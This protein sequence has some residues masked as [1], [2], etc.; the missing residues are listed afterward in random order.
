MLKKLA[1]IP[2]PV[3]QAFLNLVDPFTKEAGLLLA[4]RVKLWRFKQSILLL[5]K[6]KKFLKSR[7]VR[8]EPV[9]LKFLSS[10]LE[11]GSL[12]EDDSMVD[13][14]ASLLAAAADANHKESVLPGFSHVLDELSPKEAQLLESAYSFVLRGM[15]GGSVIESVA[16]PSQQFVAELGIAE[17]DLLVVLENLHRL[18]LIELPANPRYGG[19]PPGAPVGETHSQFCLTRLGAAFISACSKDVLRGP[20]IETNKELTYRERGS[21]VEF[22]FGPVRKKG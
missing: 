12:E 21:R 22:K 20:P 16:V 11:H 15:K 13:R 17:A 10:I 7:Q 14:W 19:W 6:A 3:K 18:R 8:P 4:D 2:T 9:P 1:S 5:E